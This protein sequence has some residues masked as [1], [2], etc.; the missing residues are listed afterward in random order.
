MDNSILSPIAHKAKQQL[1]STKPDF[2]G[3]VNGGAHA[4]FDGVSAEMSLDP[5]GQIEAAI[6][7]KYS[8]LSEGLT[9]DNPIA[10]D[11]AETFMQRAFYKVF[12]EVILRLLARGA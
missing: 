12:C 6:T 8:E 10:R 4:V 9:C 7:Q 2:V 5:N 11:A 1:L 3:C